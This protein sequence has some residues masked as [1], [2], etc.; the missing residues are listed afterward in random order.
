MA[1]PAE[2]AFFQNLVVLTT[3]SLA[4]PWLAVWPA[5]AHWPGLAGAA[6]LALTSLLIL[7]WAYARAEAQVLIPVEYTA[8]IWAA[9]LGWY[10]FDEAVTWPIIAGTALIVTGCLIAARGGR[11]QPMQVEESIA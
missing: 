3:L 11:A 7:S 8:F 10:V 5:A 4:A 9:L 2:I 1:Q 6:A